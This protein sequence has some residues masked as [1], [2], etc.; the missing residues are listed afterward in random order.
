M[1][2]CIYN[3][4]SHLPF[5]SQFCLSGTCLFLCQCCFS[6]CWWHHGEMW[7]ALCKT[8]FVCWPFFF[9]IHVL[10]PWSQSLS[11]S[12][13]LLIPIFLLYLFPV[14]FSFFVAITPPH[15]RS[16]HFLP[17]SLLLC[18]CYEDVDS[19]NWFQLA[20][21]HHWEEPVLC[22]CVCGKVEAV[23]LGNCLTLPYGKVSH[24]VPVL[25]LV[26]VCMCVAPSLR[27]HIQRCVC[28]SM[29]NE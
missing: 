10:F 23:I 2:R 21:L 18:S 16:R 29:K 27:V 20:A 28:I 8:L 14:S 25:P 22:V 12:I 1:D 26:S 9:F 19:R 3:I 15:L 11:L 4:L 5:L 24:F 6:S 13:T 7:Q 17:P